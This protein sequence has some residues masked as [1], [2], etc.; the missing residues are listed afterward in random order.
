VLVQTLNP[1]QSLNQSLCPLLHLIYDEAMVKETAYNT[2]FGV[3]ILAG[4]QVC[5]I[6]RYADDE[7][8]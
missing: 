7:D 5:N 6:I 2:P 8:K 1:A 3:L 4:G